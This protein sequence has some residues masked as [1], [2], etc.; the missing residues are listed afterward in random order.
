MRVRVPIEKHSTADEHQQKVMKLYKK[1]NLQLLKLHNDISEEIEDEDNETEESREEDL[2][3]L[4]ILGVTRADHPCKSEVLVEKQTCGMNNKPC[5]YEIYGIPRK[6]KLSF[7][8]ASKFSST[9]PNLS[10]SIL[11]ARSESWRL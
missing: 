7:S 8:Q 3:D 2:S 9:L 11:L 6:T 10:N 1:F 4:E 5:E